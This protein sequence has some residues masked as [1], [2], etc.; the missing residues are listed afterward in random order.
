MKSVYASGTDTSTR[1]RPMLASENIWPPCA[2]PVVGLALELKLPEGPW[3]LPSMAA[4][5]VPRL[6]GE[7]LDPQSRA[8]TVDQSAYIHIAGRN[9]A[10]ER[11]SHALVLLE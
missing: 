4:A 7:E 3:L 5:V 9:N 2:P 8:A 1:N 10:T 6:L 11:R